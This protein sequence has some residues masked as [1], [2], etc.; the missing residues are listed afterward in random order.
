MQSTLCASFPVL[1]FY[2]LNFYSG[3][4]ALLFPRS[5]V[6]SLSL[7]PLIMFA[8]IETGGK[9][10]R[11]APGEKLTA[12]KLSV[13]PGSSVTFDRVLLLDDGKETRVGTP[14]LEGTAV[15]AK[16]VREGR[17]RKKTVFRFHSKTRYRKNKGHRQVYTEVEV[18]KIA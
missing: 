14:Y 8:I 2:L 11:V 10:Y 18:E 6:F 13:P 7:Y 12:E 3:R 5:M 4:D 16:V 15:R 1:R 9:Q 17:G